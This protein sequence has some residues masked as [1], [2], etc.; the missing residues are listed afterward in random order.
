MMSCAL[1]RCLCRMSHA[2]T[3]S[4]SL[5]SASCSCRHSQHAVLCRALLFIASSQA[6]PSQS[7]NDWQVLRGFCSQNIGAA[8]T[9]LEVASLTSTNTPVADFTSQRVPSQ[10]WNHLLRLHLRC[11]HCPKLV[12]ER[13][14]EVVEAPARLETL[15]RLLSSSCAQ[16]RPGGSWQC[17]HAWHRSQPV[18]RSGT[19]Q[20]HKTV[21]QLHHSLH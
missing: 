6:C 11:F 12:P 19:Q 7:R 1:V 13:K 2:A 8:E 15:L 16:V 4:L 17:L 21:Q 18:A 3:A 10:I 14:A 20:P 9:R 5:F